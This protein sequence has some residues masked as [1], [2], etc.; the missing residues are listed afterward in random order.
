MTNVG[1][2]VL[3]EL[4][5]TGWEDFGCNCRLATKLSDCDLAP[6]GDSEP[7][8]LH[9]VIERIEGKGELCRSFSAP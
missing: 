4:D 1:D 8:Q 3:K 6:L 7:D 2:A 5:W 9:R